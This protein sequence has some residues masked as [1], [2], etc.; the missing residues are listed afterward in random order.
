MSRQHIVL[1][2]LLLLLALVAFVALLLGRY[3]LSPAAGVDA[4]LALIVPGHVASDP[5][6]V[7]LMSEVRLPRVLG[8]ILIGAALAVSGT[9]FQAL[10]MNPLVS[11]SAWII[12]SAL[13]RLSCSR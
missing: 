3:A 12:R 10:F 5:A 2:G 4:L 1:A 11:P 6:L 9:A 13:D 8:A 7:T